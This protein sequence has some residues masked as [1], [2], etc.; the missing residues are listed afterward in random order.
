MWPGRGPHCSLTESTGWLPRAVD[1]AAHDD[2]GMVPSAA[3]IR[4]TRTGAHPLSS[5]SR[6]RVA[7]HGP[8]SGGRRAP[9]RSGT[10]NTG[11]G[12]SGGHRRSRPPTF[13]QIHHHADH[14]TT[15][16]GNRHSIRPESLPSAMLNHRVSR[17][18]DHQPSITTRP[19]L[20]NSPRSLQLLV[21][22]QRRSSCLDSERDVNTWSETSSEIAARRGAHGAGAAAAGGHGQHRRGL[23]RRHASRVRGGVT[24]H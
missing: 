21:W 4:R 20:P 13:D 24:H 19:P 15:R 7:R 22:A 6:P 14:D 3:R 23:D 11:S 1:G 8:D 9:W 5:V 12:P 18:S 17:G 10:H 2:L 16:G